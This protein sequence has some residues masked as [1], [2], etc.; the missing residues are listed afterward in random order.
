MKISAFLAPILNGT[1]PVLQFP[2]TE[3]KQ[4]RAPVE[5]VY[6]QCLLNTY[7]L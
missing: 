6:I 1:D 4:R 2:C 3:E 7:A 5:E